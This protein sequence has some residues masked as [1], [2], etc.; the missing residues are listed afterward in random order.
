[1]SFQDNMKQN[2]QSAQSFIFIVAYV[3]HWEINFYEK[4]KISIR[5]PS[6]HFFNPIFSLESNL[7]IQ[8]WRSKIRLEKELSW[9]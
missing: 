9:K 4:H 3:I 7:H 6:V 2:N 5:Y 8:T 1:M